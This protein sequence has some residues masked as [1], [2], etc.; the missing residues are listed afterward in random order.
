MTDNLR[1]ERKFLVENRPD[2]EVRHFIGL[3]PVGFGAVFVPRTINNIYLD[4]PE[5]THYHDN[6]EGSPH[7][8]KVRIRWYG[9]LFGQIPQP[10]L[11]IK[12]KQGLLGKKLSFA[13]PPL[14]LYPHTTPASFYK[15]LQTADLP[16]DI[17]HQLPALA[18][19]TINTYHRQYYQDPTQT[20]RATIDTHLQYH[21]CGIMHHA[22]PL[23]HALTHIQIL[24]L[25]YLP[26]H[27]THA[28]IATNALPYRLTKS[29][30]Y[31]M[32]IELL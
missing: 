30:K 12:I 9:S 20:L 15:W 11:E 18:P 27:E 22:L 6:V 7:R 13:L 26:Q 17:A 4:T 25:K 32:G 14:A 1:I 29:S 28:R 5:L 31:V 21:H 10:V 3:N 8:Q 19:T 16:A 23:H 2:T 24:E